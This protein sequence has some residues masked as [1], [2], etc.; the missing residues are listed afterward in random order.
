MKSVPVPGSTPTGSVISGE[1]GGLHD[2]QR[3]PLQPHDRQPRAHSHMVE[4]VLTK[5]HDDTDAVAPPLASHDPPAK[6]IRHSEAEEVRTLRPAGFG[7]QLVAE[8]PAGPLEAP[9]FE[10][11]E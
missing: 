7:E 11:V 5:S 2:A 10:S 8:E 1:Q 4:L 6:W 3:A 9:S